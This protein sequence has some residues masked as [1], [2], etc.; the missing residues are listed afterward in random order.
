MPKAAPSFKN[1]RMAVDFY[2]EI[3]AP[4]KVVYKTVVRVFPANAK[5][6][7]AFEAVAIHDDPDNLRLSQFERANPRRVDKV[8]FVDHRGE[9]HLR[10]HKEFTVGTLYAPQSGHNGP[11]QVSL[12]W[13]LIFKID[14]DLARRKTGHVEDGL[15]HYIVDL[16]PVHNKTIERARKKLSEL[17]EQKS[18]EGRPPKS[19]S[20][21]LTERYGR[22]DPE[23]LDWIKRNS[24][25][26]DNADFSHDNYTDMVL[27]H[28][29]P[30]GE[31]E[32]GDGYRSFE[33]NY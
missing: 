33:E 1:L 11:N 15:I 6:S 4:V 20:Q 25:E 2:N 21:D 32:G 14:G 8:F 18:F 31:A 23:V 12:E 27:R 13:A 5:N 17:S 29:V 16:N 10:Q 24:A 22:D 9:Q 30:L 7:H 26:L 3:S 19:N 28:A